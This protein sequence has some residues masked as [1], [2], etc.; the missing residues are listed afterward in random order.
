MLEVVASSSSTHQDGIAGIRTPGA[1]ETVAG[2][3]RWVVIAPVSW[4]S[5]FLRYLTCSS[6]VGVDF[7]TM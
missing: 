7:S 6:P 4:L 2:A 3:V 1:A 5:S